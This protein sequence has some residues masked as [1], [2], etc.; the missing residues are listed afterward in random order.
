MA[1]KAK[2]ASRPG[3]AVS[4]TVGKRAAGGKV[5]E[6]S[7]LNR[8][9]L[10]LSAIL[11]LT[12]LVY[13]RSLNNGFVAWDDPTNVY[14]NPFIRELSGENLKTYFTK[15]L[16]AMYT[17]LVYLSFAVDYQIG[18]LDPRTYHTTNLILHLVNVSLVFMALWLLTRRTEIAA[19]AA[20]LFAV[21]PL[22][23]AAVAP[24][25]T[26]S[27]LLYALFFLA[28]FLAYIRYLQT[29]LKP[30]YIAVALGLFLLAL[31]SKS[32]AVV[33]PLVLILTDYYVG[34][35]FDRRA[36][37]EK[38]PFFALSLL[39]GILTFALREDFG[40]IGT[41]LVFPPST[42]FLSLPI[43]LPSIYSRCSSRLT[44]PHT[45]PIRSRS[46]VCS[47]SGAISPRWPSLR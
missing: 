6:K 38:I 34:R 23:T 1:R 31:L 3:P 2:I 24:V 25:S 43:R 39:F 7:R 17:P 14:E 4:P 45:I 47:R 10:I 42:G 9:L 33:L 15:P 18:G 26:R 37:G 40:Q 36:I 16:L 35:T 22:N 8:N 44:S 5:P 12:I 29:A 41:P 30:R 21:H 28:A 11:L 19:V 20:L 27:T 13:A 46:A 32:A